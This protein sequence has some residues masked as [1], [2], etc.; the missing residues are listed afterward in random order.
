M[1]EIAEVLDCS[2]QAVRTA[3]ER[4][5]RTP[6]TRY[7]R[8]SE[9]RDPTQT[10]IATLIQLYETCPQAPRNREGFRDTKGPEGRALADACRTIVDDGTPMA[11][12]STALERGPTWVHWL[13]NC[14]DLQPELHATQTTS[15]RT[16][17]ATA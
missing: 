10:E 17:D 7:P 3:L 9:R 6:P 14:H 13:L 8:L 16:R 12:L 15:R 4:A 2:R 5:G 11:T 1:D